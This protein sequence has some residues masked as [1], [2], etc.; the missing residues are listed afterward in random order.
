[1]SCAEIG[2]RRPSGRRGQ[3]R[4]PGSRGR[5]PRCQ[6]GRSRARRCRS[7]A[8]ACARRPGALQRSLRRVV[9][10]GGGHQRVDTA[11]EVLGER[12]LPLARDRRDDV[13]RP[14]G[15]TTRRRAQLLRARDRSQGGRAG[16]SPHGGQDRR[17]TGAPRGTSRAG[18]ARPPRALP[19]SRFPSGSR[20]RP[21]EGPRVR[22]RPE[23]SC[24]R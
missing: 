21:G 19:R 6:R 5:G 4:P 13:A 7:A 14:F 18:S 10:T 1:M 8:T 20:Q 2:A 15:L 9:S 24:R 11:V 23:P 22:C 3:A 12:T 16:A 17:A